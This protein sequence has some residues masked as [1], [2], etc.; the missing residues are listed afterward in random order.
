MSHSSGI[1]ASSE[2]SETFTSA[3]SGSDIRALKI[4]IE[5]DQLVLKDKLTASNS[6]IEDFGKLSGL[7]QEGVPNYFV[8]RLESENKFGYEWLLVPFVPDGCKVKQRMIYGSTQEALKRELG[9]QYFA[10]EMH[11]TAISELC[12]DTLS[13]WLTQKNKSLAEQQSEVMT[14]TEKQLKQESSLEV[15]STSSSNVHGVSFP[16]DDAGQEAL[17]K[18]SQGQ[19]SFVSLGL[20]IPGERITLSDSAPEIGIEDLVSR[21]SS[22]EPRFTFYRFAY[23]HEGEAH[24]ST[25]FIYSCPDASPIKTRMVYSTTKGSALLYGKAFDIEPEKKIE[26]TDLEDLTH[27]YLYEYLHPPKV[28]KKRFRKPARP[29]KGKARLIRSSN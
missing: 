17:K 25:F 2:V 29:G 14:E 1:P 19:N 15:G 28:E 11:L 20:D 5:N 8:F 21:I 27:K 7:A 18:F 22:D 12:Q 24:D 10:G 13:Q 9:Q 16:L 4:S 6:E 23:D 26:V 3:R